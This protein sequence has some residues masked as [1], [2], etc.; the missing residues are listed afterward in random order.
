MKPRR[1]AFDK[2]NATKFR[3]LPDLPQH[4]DETSGQVV[5]IHFFAHVFHS[6]TIIQTLDHDTRKSEQ[7]K[8]GILY[9]DEYDYMQHLRSSSDGYRLEPVT[10][11]KIGNPLLNFFNETEVPMDLKQNGNVPNIDYT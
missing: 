10:Q 1:K 4:S 7:I 9:D 8:Y 2:K 6:F 5:D 11:V 3:V